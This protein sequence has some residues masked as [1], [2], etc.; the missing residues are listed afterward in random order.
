VQR[1]LALATLHLDTAG[2]NVHA[3]LRDRDAS[4]AETLLRELP[5]VCRV[6]RQHDGPRRDRGAAGG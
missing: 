4:E 6:A 5:D 1:R 3:V 2:R